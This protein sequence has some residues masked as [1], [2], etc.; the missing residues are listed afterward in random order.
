MNPTGDQK[1]LERPDQYG[2]GLSEIVVDL[3]DDPDYVYGRRAPEGCVAIRVHGAGA[4]DHFEAAELPDSGDNRRGWRCWNW[5]WARASLEEAR[6]AIA[7]GLLA[8]LIVF[9][10]TIPSMAGSAVAPGYHLETRDSG[11]WPCRT[12]TTVVVRDPTF[13]PTPRPVQPDVQ[14]E[15][16]RQ[17]AFRVII[18]GPALK[19]RYIARVKATIEA[20]PADQKAALPACW[21]SNFEAMMASEGFERYA[22]ELEH[23]LAGLTLEELEQLARSGQWTGPKCSKIMTEMNVVLQTQARVMSTLA[24]E[25]NDLSLRVVLNNAKKLTADRAARRFAGLDVLSAR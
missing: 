13:V 10:M 15:G 25:V 11:W 3:L 4:A 1:M 20:M 24:L 6:T 12:T 19:G 23:R 8:L 9:T 5:F 18:D 21:S 14:Q 22:A 7:N 2:L 17:A 16:R